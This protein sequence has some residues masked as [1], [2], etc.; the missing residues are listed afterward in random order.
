MRI[1]WTDSA[2][3]S[4]DAAADYIF[5]EFGAMSL[6]DFYD[7]LDKIE[8]NLIAFSEMGKVEPLLRDR[9]IL[10][11][12]VVASKYNKIIYFVEGDTI[13]IVDFWDTRREPKAQARR[14]K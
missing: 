10:Y 11:R 5:D 13:Y 3:R 8:S 2:Q 7:N 14:V 12:S 1:I 4:Q 9:S 6:H